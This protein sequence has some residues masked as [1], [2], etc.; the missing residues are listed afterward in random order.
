MVWK[1]DVAPKNIFLMQHIKLLLQF[2]TIPSHFGNISIS[3][4]FV[5]SSPLPNSMLFIVMKS[6]LLVYNIVGG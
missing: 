5:S 3:G 4:K 1:A 6:S 2:P